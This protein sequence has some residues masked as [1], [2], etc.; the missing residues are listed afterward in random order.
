[1]EE[2]A[3]M[4]NDQ[5]P[6]PQDAEPTEIMQMCGDI[7]HG[8]EPE[9]EEWRHQF[10]EVRARELLAVGGPFERA[11]TAVLRLFGVDAAGRESAR[12][13]LADV[14][15]RLALPADGELERL[16][17]ERVTLSCMAV[18]F[19]EGQRAEEWQRSL[20]PAETTYWDRHVS[21]L[22]GDFLKACRTLAD[23]RRLARPTVLAQMNIAEQQQ[24]NISM[25]GEPVLPNPAGEDNAAAP[26][27][28]DG[29]G[30]AR[31]GLGRRT[32]PR[33]T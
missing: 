5:L 12:Q 18:D 15:Q 29:T 27:F 13:R 21:T 4:T 8:R 7:L 24:I 19:A 28:D 1:M 10:L 14:R 16:V 30:K 3:L 31:R 33:E 17:I 11:E 22:S 2:E 23:V 6:G 25:D 20:S 9:E 26:S 32:A